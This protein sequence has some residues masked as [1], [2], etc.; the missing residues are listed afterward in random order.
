MF[1]SIKSW[2]CRIG[3][4]DK[5]YAFS[6]QPQQPE[7]YVNGW[8]I[9]DAR[10]EFHRMGISEKESDK[11]W[12]LSYSNSDYSVSSTIAF[13]FKSL[14]RSPSFLQHIRA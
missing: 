1:D 11:G 9:Y 13:A 2:T 3:R 10:K 6:Y 14:L 7:K 12:R 5:L 4:V 8:S